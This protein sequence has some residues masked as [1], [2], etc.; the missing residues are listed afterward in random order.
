MQINT[1]IQEASHVVY[2]PITSSLHYH[3]AIHHNN[4]NNTKIIL[5][6]ARMISS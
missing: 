3:V 2:T 6:N 5:R 1:V 4:N